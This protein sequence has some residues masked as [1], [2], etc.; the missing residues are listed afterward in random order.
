MT[1]TPLK[2]RLYERE[3]HFR[4]SLDE[5]ELVCGPA[6]DEVIRRTA[7]LMIKPEGVLSGKLDAICDFLAENDFAIVSTNFVTFHRLLWRELWRYQL[8][9]ATLD[10]LLVAD[11][12]LSAGPGLLLVLRSSPGHELPATV[13]LT[14]RKGSASLAQQTPGTLRHRLG[15]ANRVLSLLHVADEPADLIRELGILFDRP[16][17]RRVYRTMC[18]GRPGSAD[19]AALAEARTTEPRSLGASEALERVTA[20]VRERRDVDPVVAQ[21]VLADLARMR[22]GERIEWRPFEEGLTALDVAADDWDLIVLGTSFIVYDE[23]GASKVLVNPDPAEWLQP[24][25]DELL[26]SG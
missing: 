22:A 23:P 5:A 9:S 17:R 16:E 21:A 6:F 26:I 4:E 12:H 8:T 7:L 15:Q 14:S 2:A 13:R 20:A 18:T 1:R 3:T 19:L 24:S 25:L 10:R 11:R